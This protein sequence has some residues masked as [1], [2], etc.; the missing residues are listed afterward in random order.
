MEEPNDYHFA[1]CY[2]LALRILGEKQFEKCHITF[3]YADESLNEFLIW[4]L[5]F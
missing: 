1:I 4:F 5:S 2:A 3:I